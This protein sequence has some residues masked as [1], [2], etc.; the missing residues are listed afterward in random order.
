MRPVA[1]DDLVARLKPCPVD[2]GPDGIANAGVR[3][4][5]V[6]RGGVSGPGSMKGPCQVYGR[7]MKGQCALVSSVQEVPNVRSGCDLRFYE[8]RD[9][10]VV[11][12]D[13]V[14]ADSRHFGARRTAPTDV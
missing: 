6:A 7:Y 11:P 13:A 14:R 5:G 8:D 10:A 3:V 2:Q 12:T 1:G 9:H 4:P